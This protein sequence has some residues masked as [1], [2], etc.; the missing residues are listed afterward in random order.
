MRVLLLAIA[1]LLAVTQSIGGEARPCFDQLPGDTQ[2]R[3]DD[4]ENTKITKIAVGSPDVYAYIATEY[5]GAGNLQAEVYLREGTRYCLAG[6]LGTATDFH[7]GNARAARSLRNI[8]VDS[9]SGPSKF[10]RTFS[11]ALGPRAYELTACQTRTAGKPW[12]RCDAT[13]FDER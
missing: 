13:E 8:V 9:K 4:P 1:L 10:R 12:R 2:A 3:I 11:Y 5:L 6:T 7:V